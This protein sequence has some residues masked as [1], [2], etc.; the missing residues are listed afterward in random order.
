M[1]GVEG[2]LAIKLFGPDLFV[3]QQKAKE[4]AGVLRRIRGVAD[5]DYDH[6]IGQ[7]QLQIVVDRAAAARYG[8]NVQDVQDVLETATKG[9]TVTE[10]FEKERRFNL[11]VRFLQGADPIASLQSVMVS[12]PSAERIPLRQLAEFK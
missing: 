2:E 10:I 4:I 1:A 5:L 12:A 8:I 9:R 6:L 3:L 11:V 7:P